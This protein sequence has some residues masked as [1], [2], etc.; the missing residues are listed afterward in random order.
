MLVLQKSCVPACQRASR[1]SA[2]AASGRKN[3]E[4]S[5]RIIN[6][7]PGFISSVAVLASFAGI[8]VTAASGANILHPYWGTFLG[9]L[10]GCAGLLPQAA[11]ISKL[12]ENAN[13]QNQYIRAPI[14]AVTLTIPV[15]MIMAMLFSLFVGP[16]PR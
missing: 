13:I 8:A 5:M 3:S 16:W 1:I 10:V 9:I 7:S 2:M 12:L 11:A 4:A 6:L 15:I 14:I